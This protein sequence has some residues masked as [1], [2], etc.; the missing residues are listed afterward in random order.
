MTIEGSMRSHAASLSRPELRSA[1]ID[2]LVEACDAIEDRTGS[3]L[4]AKHRRE[5]AP[6]RHGYEITSTNIEHY[7]R[8]KGWSGPVRVTI[9]RDR[10]YFRPYVEAREFERPNKRARRRP[11]ARTQNVENALSSV[12]LVENRVLLREELAR[13][14]QAI[15]DLQLLKQGLNNIAPVAIEAL[16]GGQSGE[17]R[18]TIDD[19]LCDESRR[20]LRDLILRLQDARKMGQFGLV[21]VNDRLQQLGGLEDT[22]VAIAEMR[23]LK[24][25]ARLPEIDS[26]SFEIDL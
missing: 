24:R 5:A 6:P 20:L 17:T 9:E 22:L 3:D 4:I 16:L 15:R 26:A 10:Q 8:A 19:H 25:L 1:T 13:G 12:P 14:S 23:L 18:S 21:L 7:V 2:R 11:S